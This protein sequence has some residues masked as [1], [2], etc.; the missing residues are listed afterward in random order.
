MGDCDNRGYGILKRVTAVVKE[1][2]ILDAKAVEGGYLRGGKVN[3]SDILRYITLRYSLYQSSESVTW[4]VESSRRAQ[5]FS[6]VERRPDTGDFFYRAETKATGT[7]I[8][9]ILGR[10]ILAR[11][12]YN[13]FL[14]EILVDSY[15]VALLLATIYIKK[16]GPSKVRVVGKGAIIAKKKGIKR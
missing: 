1:E 6:R 10:H 11:W 12:N 3:I 14:P 8:A 15:S 7:S 5:F 13:G 2:V 9:P 16:E 4:G